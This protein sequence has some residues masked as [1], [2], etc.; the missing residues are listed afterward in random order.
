MYVYQS[1]FLQVATLQTLLVFDFCGIYRFL[2]LNQIIY[3]HEM[4]LPIYPSLPS[5]SCMVFKVEGET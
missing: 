5:N 4:I 1:I 3:N 2:P